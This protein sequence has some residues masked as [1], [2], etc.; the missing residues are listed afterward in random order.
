[1]NP[2]VSIFKSKI[3]I[4]GVSA[5]IFI[6][7]WIFSGSLSRSALCAQDSPGKLQKNAQL[8]AKC[9][10]TLCFLLRRTIFSYG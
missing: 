5:I 3:F 6:P 9:V 10:S 8:S 7:F 4:I 1:M 2:L